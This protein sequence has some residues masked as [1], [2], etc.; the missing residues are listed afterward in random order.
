[1]IEELKQ[2]N[3][4]VKKEEINIVKNLTKNDFLRNVNFIPLKYINFKACKN[5]EFYFYYSFP[6][7][8]KILNDFIQFEKDKKSFYTIEDGSDR[9]KIFERILKYQFRVHKK[10]NIDGYFKVEDLINMKPTKKYANINQEYFT[11]KN[12]IFIDQKDPNAEDYDFAIYKPKSKQLLLFQAKYII[13]RG[14]VEKKKSLY[15][16]TA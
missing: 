2:K 7:F 4:I 5:G 15:D 10:F 3:Y 8:K 6:L 16:N 9:G 1:M 11:S 12:S 13:N 14:T